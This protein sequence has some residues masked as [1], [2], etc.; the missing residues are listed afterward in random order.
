MYN[1]ILY[2]RTKAI[3]TVSIIIRH[4]LFA[5]FKPRH[6]AI[7]IWYLFI[8]ASYHLRKI[9]INLWSQ[10]IS[11]SH[12]PTLSTTEYYI[13]DDGFT[14]YLSCDNMIFYRT[15]SHYAW[16][17]Y[18]LLACCFVLVFKV[19]FSNIVNYIVEVRCFARLQSTNQRR[20]P[21]Q[22]N[23][24]QIQIMSKLSTIKYSCFVCGWLRNI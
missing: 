8:N 3:S 15:V 21:W 23:V 4:T 12:N 6:I 22:D 5:I 16:Q 1:Y 9:I 14:S 13:I 24:Q 20:N 11:R 2:F 17:L 7:N 19:L 18:Y 10:L